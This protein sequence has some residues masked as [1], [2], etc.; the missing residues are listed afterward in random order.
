MPAPTDAGREVSSTGTNVS[1]HTIY[2]GSPAAGQLLV[3]VVRTG[4]PSTI[5]VP[6]F[7]LLG[8]LV[9]DGSSDTMQVLTKVA[10]GTEGASV[11]A[12]TSAYIQAAKGEN[13]DA[14]V[15][16]AVETVGLTTISA[17][18]LTLFTVLRGDGGPRAKRAAALLNENLREP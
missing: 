9:A 16:R 4:L 10:D 7:T 2:L 8:E 11:G 15:R 3:L 18:G 12:T 14:D 1:S 17:D 5:D 6:G 13:E